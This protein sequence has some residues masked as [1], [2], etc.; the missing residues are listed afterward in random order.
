VATEYVF[1]FF[2]KFATVP[3]IIDK[4]D[5]NTTIAKHFRAIEGGAFLMLTRARLRSTW[6]L[7]NS[8]HSPELPQ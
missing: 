3:F 8:D 2:V 1:F 7:K 6:N 4:Q 5:F